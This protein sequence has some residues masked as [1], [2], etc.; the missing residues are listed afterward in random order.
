ME[1]H[2]NRH[3]IEFE[4]L[5]Q[6]DIA[7]LLKWCN[8]CCFARWRTNS[9]NRGFAFVFDSRFD[10]ELFLMTHSDY[11]GNDIERNT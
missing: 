7:R 8:T 3:I 1:K 4:H 5:R 9:S 2:P 10:A 11:F 6:Q